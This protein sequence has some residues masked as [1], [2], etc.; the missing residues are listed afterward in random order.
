MFAGA[1]SVILLL[2]MFSSCAATM[3]SICSNFFAVGSMKNKI[4]A[5]IIVLA[6][7]IIS[8]FPFGSLVGMIFPLIGYYG[9][10]Y[11]GC[12]IYKG[13]KRKVL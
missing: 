4:T 12:V 6:A 7:Y 3:W 2:G 9:F 5:A 11:I 10:I 8:L 13:L 1:F